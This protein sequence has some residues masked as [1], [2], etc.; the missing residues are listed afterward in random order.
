MN[1][2]EIDV[3]NGINTTEF[4]LYLLAFCHSL[5]HIKNPTI[6]STWLRLSLIF[7]FWIFP[8]AMLFLTQPMEAWFFRFVMILAVISEYVFDKKEPDRREN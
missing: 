1:L 3:I 7:G 2:S 5:Y 4:G 6:K 8:S